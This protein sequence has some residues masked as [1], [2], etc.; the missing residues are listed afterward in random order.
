MSVS[1]ETVQP[2]KFL[3]VTG[4]P[5]CTFGCEYCNPKREYNPVMMPTREVLDTVRAGVELGIDTVHLTGGEPSK[6][7]DIVR[8]VAGIKDEGVQTIEMT[9][10]GVPFYRLVED[11]AAA[12]LN[13]V[14]IS[15]DTL[16]REKFHQITG[17]DALP[18]VLEAIEKSRHLFER[19]VALNMVVMRKNLAEM[20]DMAEFARQTGI[21]VRFCELTPHGPYMQV[22]PRLF[23]EQ[24]VPKDEIISVLEGL[25]PMDGA[26]KGKID[27]Q[28]AHSEYLTLGGDFANMTVGIIAP[29]SNGWPCPGTDCV[30]LRIGPTSANSCVVYPERNLMGLSYAGKKEVLEALIEERRQQMATN[31]FPAHHQPAYLLYRFGLPEPAVE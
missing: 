16:D 14:N 7:K 4:H 2:F 29:Y 1:T 3:R 19:Q 5:G 26:D 9:T 24:H 12:G 25:A 22:N 11:L 13:G 8:L 15:L 31:G 18:Y 27:G 30:R 10:N 20:R 23:P 17:A 6:R 21:L 28:N